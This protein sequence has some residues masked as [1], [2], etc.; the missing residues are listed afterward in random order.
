MKCNPL[1]LACRSGS[2]SVLDIVLNNCNLEFILETLESLNEANKTPLHEACLY[3]DW[4][5]MKRIVNAYQDQSTLGTFLE[6]L[7]DIKEGAKKAPFHEACRGGG[8][9]MVK[10]L[11]EKLK[12]EPDF[13]ELVNI[14]D[15]FMRTPLHYACELR[16][17][18]MTG[19]LLNEKAKFL[20]DKFGRNPLH[21]AAR[22]G[23]KDV[24][25]ELLRI[26]QDEIID[27]EDQFYETPLFHAAKYHRLEVVEMLVDK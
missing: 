19:L 13:A 12:L 9:E 27:T 14:G 11:F 16:S 25:F 15:A 2:I 8:T 3:G 4:A 10:M 5:V 1:H 23:R 22:M 21:I 20:K 18:D 24:V 17:V 26:G 7:M 6:A